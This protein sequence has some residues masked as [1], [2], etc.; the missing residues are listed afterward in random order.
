MVV[1][2]ADIGGPSPIWDT[3]AINSCDFRPHFD[4][5]IHNL[6][7]TITPLSTR[8]ATARR[9][10]L[11]GCLI[12]S[13]VI[14]NWRQFRTNDRVQIIVGWPPSVRPTGRQCIKIGGDRNAIVRLHGDPDMIQLRDGWDAGLFDTP[15]DG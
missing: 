14:E 3:V 9:F 5:H 15:N 10:R 4:G 12:V 7:T 1:P 8:S 13:W 2:Q 6:W 11:V